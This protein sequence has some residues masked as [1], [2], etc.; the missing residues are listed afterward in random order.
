MDPNCATPRARELKTSG[1]TI[2]KSPRRKTWPI[3]SST[4]LR[5]HA[6]DGL[7][8]HWFNARPRAMPA[9]RPKISRVLVVCVTRGW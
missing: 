5:S 3:G 4:F 8:P 1:T 2:M 6:R 9:I 7:S